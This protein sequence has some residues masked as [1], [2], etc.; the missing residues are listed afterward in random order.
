MEPVRLGIIGCGVI[1]S[2]HLRYAAQNPR[3]AVVAVADLIPE[4]VSAAQE[5]YQ[6]PKAYG[7]GRELLADPDVEAVVLAMPANVRTALALDALRAG[8]HTLIEK[9]I[10][11]N[12]AEVRAIIAARGDRVA[13]CCS[14]RYRFLPSAQATAA[15][16]A[17]G[18]LG[19]IRVVRARAIHSAK[20]PPARMPPTWRLRRAENGGGILMNWGCYD[21]D[22]L[23]GITGWT[24]QPQQVF[25]QTW[26]VPPAYESHIAPDSDAE[27]HFAALIRCA[28]GSVI[29]FERGE[30]VAAAPDEAWQI[31]GSAGSLRLNMMA[32][33]GKRIVFDRASTSR[34][35]VSEV[36]WEGDEDNEMYHGGPVRDLA[37]AIRE[38]RPPMTTLE[39]ALLIQQISDAI[40][41]SAARGLS[42]PL[43]A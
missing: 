41:A 9:P 40:Y 6:V 34:G 4:R 22:Y 13:A 20:E 16:I 27:T 35:V 1:G 36:I 7:E 30:Y 32:E 38:G 23:L 5:Q 11:M 28:G 21:L 33:H 25:A 42:V 39:N 43:A 18:A 26:C 29:S 12:A 17:T 8:K 24:L 3:V 19:E 15:F 37:A 31:I 14:S 2:V 10:A